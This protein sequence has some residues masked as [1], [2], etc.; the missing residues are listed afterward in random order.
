MNV[1]GIP[2]EQGVAA[3]WHSRLE[4]LEAHLSGITRPE[5]R[6]RERC[7]AVGPAYRRAIEAEIGPI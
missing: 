3:G 7:E 5:G 1:R 4:A 2:D 6:N